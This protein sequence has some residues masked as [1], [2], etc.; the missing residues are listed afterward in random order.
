[1]SP[2]GAIASHYVASGGGPASWNDA[3][4][5]LSPSAWYKMDEASGTTLVAAVGSNGVTAASNITHNQPS[6][7]PSDASGKSKISASGAQIDTGTIAYDFST[8]FTV[9]WV[10]KGSTSDVAGNGEVF[11]TISVNHL[12]V[13]VTATDLILAALSGT[14]R[15]DALCARGDLLDSAAHM[16]TLTLVNNEQKFYLGST[17]KS[18]FTNAATMSNSSVIRFARSG[19]GNYLSGNYDE[20]IF[21]PSVL[22]GTQISTLHSSFTG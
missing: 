17:L 19:A 18:T 7:V 10:Y 11:R 20:L 15:T 4:A 8:G 5:A 2:F 3:V 22:T 21:V 12:A 16:C 14:T 13:R 6:L 9:I 1:M